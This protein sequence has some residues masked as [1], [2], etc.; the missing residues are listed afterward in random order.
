MEH[1]VKRWFINNPSGASEGV[2][3]RIHQ[4]LSSSRLVV[5]DTKD[6]IAAIRD[7]WIEVWSL[8]DGSTQKVI[9]DDCRGFNN[10]TWICSVARG[11]DG[12]GDSCLLATG[13]N[14][15]IVFL[16]DVS[17]SRVLKCLKCTAEN[18]YWVQSVAA[19]R[20]LVVTCNNFGEIKLWDFDAVESDSAVRCISSCFYIR[21]HWDALKSDYKRYKT[22]GED[23]ILSN[24]FSSKPISQIIALRAVGTFC[25]SQHGILKIWSWDGKGEKHY[26]GMYALK[27]Y[28]PDISISS[29]LEMRDGSLLLGL[30]DGRIVTLK[31]HI[32]Q[33]RYRGIHLHDT[34]LSFAYLYNAYHIVSHL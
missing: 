15:E 24:S 12:D 1:Q 4:V 20:S 31:R 19:T 9:K 22:D 17:Q 33:K 8:K 6:T 2:V 29:M 28:H 18:H 7:D 23:V 27:P 5:L 11:D 32:S 14:D 34:L 3:T 25:T 16:L 26:H 13:S 21:K 10:L 30:S